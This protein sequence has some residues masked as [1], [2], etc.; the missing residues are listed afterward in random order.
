MGTLLTAGV[1]LIA[2]A[3]TSARLDRLGVTSAIVFVSAG[4]AVGGAGWFDVGAASEV[5]QRVTEVAL[6][7]LLFSDSARLDLRALRDHLAWPSR[8]LLIG[9][10]LTMLLG[11]GAGLLLFPGLGLA[12]AFLLS[13]MLCS[14]DAAL[15]QRVVEDPAVPA[16]VRQA[17]D[18]ESGLNDGLAVPFFLVALDISLA[19]L[20]S[21]VPS[22]VFHNAAEQ[23]GW[24]LVAGI[25][26]GV[27]A[28]LVFRRSER[29]GWLH[30]Q[31]VQL[32]TIAAALTGYAAAA[33]LGGSGF[34][35]A[36]VG[37]M[38]F[39]HVSREHGLR[40]T[41]FTEETGNLLAAVTWIGFGAVAVRTVWPEIG[42]RV[43]AYAL[44]SLTVVRMV[45][46]AVAF[47]RS[48]AR[49]PTVAFAGW[50]GPRGL[51]S[52]VFG[53]IALEHGIPDEETIL[54]TVV[55][56][57][58]LSVLLHGLTAL[59][60]VAAYRR[61]YDGAGPRAGTGGE[62][63]GEAQDTPVPRARRRAAPASAPAATAI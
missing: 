28:G 57:V 21:A 53:L 26:T 6:V 2:Y 59:P 35:A 3:A 50:F 39:G 25:G 60:L 52:V 22:A 62:A 1:I 18:V 12:G 36:F 63:V 54:A 33:T 61:W 14:T 13:T 44:L 19:T 30:G 10:P 37:G 29:A 23:I 47:T 49:W 7:L 41:A 42:W 43:L 20:D 51:A 32:F 8:L 31:W 58:A 24:G 38:A 15:G 56:T 17:L 5:A 16:R 45:P 4:L 40:A 11:I 46:V 27:L 55:V 9:L 48:G 34:I